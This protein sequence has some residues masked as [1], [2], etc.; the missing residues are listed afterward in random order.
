[1][2]TPLFGPRILTNLFDVFTPK[3]DRLMNQMSPQNEKRSFW[4]AAIF[5]QVADLL[6]KIF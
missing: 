6:A 5:R 4:G 3:R 1:M 2:R